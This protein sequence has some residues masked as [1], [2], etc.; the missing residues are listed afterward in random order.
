[1]TS[2][3]TRLAT[4]PVRWPG[5][6]NGANLRT[7]AYTNNLLN[8]ITSRGV[9]G[10]VDVMGLTLATNTVSVN[11]QAAYQKWEYFREQLR[12]QQHPCGVVDEHD[13]DVA[14]ANDNSGHVFVAQNPE[15]FTYDLDGNQTSDGRWTNTWDGENRLI[16]MTSLTSAPAGSQY[17]LTLHV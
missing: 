15:R 3:L 9:P 4:G 10:Y 11:G 13:R 17:S 5:A 8:Q 14:G 1:M 12:G 6:T 16:N 7:N 2:R